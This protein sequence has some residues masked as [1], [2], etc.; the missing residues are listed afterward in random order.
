MAGMYCWTH[1]QR[2]AEV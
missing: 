2:Q 1:H